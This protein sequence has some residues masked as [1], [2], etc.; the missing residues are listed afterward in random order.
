MALLPDDYS[1]P[2]TQHCFNASQQFSSKKKRDINLELLNPSR[3]RNTL[4][5]RGLCRRLNV[6]SCSTKKSFFSFNPKSIILCQPELACTM[7]DSHLVC[8]QV[9]IVLPDTLSGWQSPRASPVIFILEMPTSWRKNKGK[10]ISEDC[11]HILAFWHLP[12]E[13]PINYNKIKFNRNI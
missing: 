12:E 8:T 10:R 3:P 6:S 1:F 5:G 11:Q 2:M 9:G 7:A 13:A 4:R